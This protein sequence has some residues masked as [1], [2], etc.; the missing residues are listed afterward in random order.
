VIPAPGSQRG[1]SRTNRRR[2][3]I[4]GSPWDRTSSRCSR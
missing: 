4:G 2:N 3:G 1:V